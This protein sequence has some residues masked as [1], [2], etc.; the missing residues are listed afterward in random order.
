M[1]SAVNTACWTRWVRGTERPVA[2]R[3]LRGNFR[4]AGPANELFTGRWF[5]RLP[6]VVALR[7]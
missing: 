6:E 4:D 5:D 7:R 1:A 3:A 2:I